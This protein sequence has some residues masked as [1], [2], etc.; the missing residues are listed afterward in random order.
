ME[1]LNQ[2]KCLKNIN[3]RYGNRPKDRMISKFEQ[4]AFNNFSEVYEISFLRLD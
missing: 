2:Q 4:K 1:A 3:D